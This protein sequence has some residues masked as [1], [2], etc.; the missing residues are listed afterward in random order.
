MWRCLFCVIEMRVFI[1]IILFVQA[2][3]YG[4]S[5]VA[6]R[7]YEQSKFWPTFV[8]LTEDVEGEDYKLKAGV[9][10]VL[11][12]LSDNGDSALVDFGRKGM[13]CVSTSSTDTI[14]EAKKLEGDISHKDQPNLTS[15]LSTRL[16]KVNEGRAERFPLD[17]SLETET[18]MCLRF[19]N[20]EKAWNRVSYEVSLLQEDIN[21]QLVKIVLFPVSSDLSDKSVLIRFNEHKISHAS[22]MYSFLAQ[23]YMEILWYDLPKD[24]NFIEI[25]VFDAEGK[26]V[27]FKSLPVSED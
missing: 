22:F 21:Q 16:I 26:L 14:V 19:A 7:L 13:H 10:G 8:S 18:Y 1:L 23:S 15:L 9:R 12:R 2:I 17:Q 24:D 20:T 5:L 3:S 4:N 27:N 11:I 25:V 6:K